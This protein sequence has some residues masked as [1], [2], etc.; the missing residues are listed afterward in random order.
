[1]FDPNKPKIQDKVQ[2]KVGV[3]NGTLQHSIAK[4]V[5]VCIP[6]Y[7]ADS[8]PRPASPGIYCK[9]DGH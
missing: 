9:F 8:F 6:I 1:M 5:G 2:Y 3:T 7:R 4:F